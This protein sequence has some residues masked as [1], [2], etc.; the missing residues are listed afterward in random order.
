MI[1]SSI[2]ILCTFCV[3]AISPVAAFLQRKINLLSHNDGYAVAKEIC[4]TYLNF[5]TF[6]RSLVCCMMFSPMYV[7]V[8]SYLYIFSCLISC[9]RYNQGQRQ[10]SRIT[11]LWVCIFHDSFLE[12][13]FLVHFLQRRNIIVCHTGKNIVTGTSYVIND[14]NSNKVNGWYYFLYMKIDYME[15][16]VD[17]HFSSVHE[18]SVPIFLQQHKIPKKI[19]GHNKQPTTCSTASYL[20]V[21]LPCP[22]RTYTDSYELLNPLLFTPSLA[23]WERIIVLFP[24]LCTQ[25]IYIVRYVHV[26][27]TS[28][29]NGSVHGAFFMYSLSCRNPVASTP[30]HGGV[31]GTPSSAKRLADI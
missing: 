11:A 18:C 16:I 17:N 12:T 14:R 27:C 20:K 1:F 13:N 9:F 19:N 7:E 2:F 3:S 31:E 29:V 8:E 6:L 23:Q 21:H 26:Q 4:N 22:S 15:V 24:S 5:Q 10:T 30:I 28:T 25:V